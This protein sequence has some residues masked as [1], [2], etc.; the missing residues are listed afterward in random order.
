MENLRKLR[1]KEG[2]T[3]KELAEK[4]NMS[5]ASIAY[6][7]I[8]RRS[9]DINRAKKLADY[10]GVSVDYIAYGEGKEGVQ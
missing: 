6:Y 8:G 10:F 9:P 4:L 7:E 5:R 1:R 3:Q 2:L